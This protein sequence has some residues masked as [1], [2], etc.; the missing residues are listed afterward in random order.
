MSINGKATILS[1]RSF[2]KRYP[3][4]RV[5]RSSKEQGKVFVCRRGCNTRTATYT[6]EFDW[7][8]IYQGSPDIP[9]LI[10]RVQDQTKATRKRKRKEDYP[11]EEAVDVCTTAPNGAMRTLTFC[12][13]NLRAVARSQK[14][15][16]S[17]ERP[18]KLRLRAPSLDAPHR[19]TQRH[20]TD[21]KHYFFFVVSP[22]R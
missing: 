14:H 13:G 1:T 9:A 6:E 17:D 10:Q 3:S 18:S 20:S 4:G 12:S 8:S 11:E 16:A 5:P 7:E 19:N 21:G 2:N 22:V 15:P